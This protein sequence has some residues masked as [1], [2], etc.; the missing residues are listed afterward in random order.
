MRITVVD[1]IRQISLEVEERTL[2]LEVMVRDIQMMQ[3]KVRSVVGDISSLQTAHQDFIHA[4][5]RIG[6]I[7]EIVQDSLVHLDEEDQ[8]ALLAYF[9][10]VESQA[11]RV[12]KG[13]LQTK[14]LPTEKASKEKVK[15]LKLE[16]FK[17]MPVK[18][19]IH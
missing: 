17:D 19:A 12:I 11:N 2:P 14:S 10:D 3:F 8:E 15:L 7:D 9:K 6:K 13:A 18:S 5:W 4:L 1:I 16:I